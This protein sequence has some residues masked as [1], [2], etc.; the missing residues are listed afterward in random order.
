M[1][2]LRSTVPELERFLARLLDYGTWIACGVIVV[3]LVESF[4]FADAR[5]MFI[6]KLGVGLVIALPI[7]RV[8]SML[9][10]FL[11]T[12]DYRFGWIAALVLIIIFAGIFLGL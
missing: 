1:N 8:M 10:Y 7:I 4:A 5:G 9:A 6:V 3:G 2:A 12:G 11:K